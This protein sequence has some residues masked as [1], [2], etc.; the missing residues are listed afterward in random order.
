VIVL[1]IFNYK[2]LFA[3]HYPHKRHCKSTWKEP[4]VQEKT[5]IFML[6]GSSWLRGESFFVFPFGGVYP[7]QS[8]TGSGLKAN[9][10]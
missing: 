6:R 8:R 9:S 3:F 2:N 10:G 4:D 5:I 1:A 7:E